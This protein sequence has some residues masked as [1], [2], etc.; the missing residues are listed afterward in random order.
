[1]GN[2]ADSLVYRALVASGGRSG[3]GGESGGS[4]VSVPAKDVNF[5]DYD[6]V[7]LYS[8]TL[9]EANALTA[10][11]DAPKH[12]G[13]TFQRWNY[14]LEK[15]QSATQPMDVGATYISADGKTRLYIYIPPNSMVGREPPRNQVPIRFSQTVDNGVTIDWGDGSAPETVSGTGNKSMTHEYA[16][17]GDFV[18]SLYPSDECTLG[19][20]WDLSSVCVMGGTGSSASYDDTN[21]AYRNMLKHV[22]IG[23][24]VTNIS[25]GA[26]YNCYSLSSIVMPEHVTSI[27]SYVFNSCKS[28]TAIVVPD[29]VPS[30]GNYAVQNCNALAVFV[31][32]DS[33]TSFG[34]YAVYGCDALSSLVLPHGINSSGI[35]AIASCRSMLYL[36]LT[37]GIASIYDGMFRECKSLTSVTIPSSVSSIGDSVFN[38]CYGLKE[39]HVLSMTPPTLG[40]TVFDGIQSDCTI[41]VPRGCLEAYQTSTNWA[42]YADHIQEEPT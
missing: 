35:Q 20:G 33:I 4:V 13:L 2:I 16:A 12:D 25:A 40:S 26:F 24:G 8:Y 14:A 15:V 10:M 34:Q 29:G 30:L 42:T 27:G 5:Y 11:P 21:A 31:I 22:V 19:L 9:E 39:V 18:I 41:Y 32:P 38:K 6:G 3:G 36:V 23:R 7:R 28:L 17:P 1:M 37:D